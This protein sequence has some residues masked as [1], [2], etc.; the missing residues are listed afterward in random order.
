MPLALSSVPSCN[1][2]NCLLSAPQAADD[3]HLLDGAFVVPGADGITV[4]TYVVPPAPT[5]PGA[6]EPFNCSSGLIDQR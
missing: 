2:E 5:V 6:A 4:A 3:F 1:G